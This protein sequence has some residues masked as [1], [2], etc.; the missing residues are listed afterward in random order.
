VTGA[1]LV[2]TALIGLAAALAG[3]AAPV[4]F[5][6]GLS[7]ALTIGACGFGLIVG[8][9]VLRSGHPAEVHTSALMPLS[10]FSLS[11]DRFGALFVVITAVVGICAMVFRLGYTGHGLSSRTA[12]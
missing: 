11:L 2:G 5:R 12:S 3:A 10:G 7:T 4:R 6:I 9:D 1:L 8:V